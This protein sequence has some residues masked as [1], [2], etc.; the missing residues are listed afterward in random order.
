[1]VL[2]NGSL[3]TAAAPLG[4][5]CSQSVRPLPSGRLYPLAVASAR[6]T[7]SAA[8]ALPCA[9]RAG[10]PCNP[11][12]RVVPVYMVSGVHY[13]CVSLFLFSYSH[14]V[15]AVPRSHGCCWTSDDMLNA[16]SDCLHL[17]MCLLG[18][19]E[20]V[21]LLLLFHLLRGGDWPWLFQSSQAIA[22]T[23]RMQRHDPAGQAG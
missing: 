2:T 3:S 15:Q 13:I 23:E 4:A 22:G 14:A 6:P 16:R 10:R 9:L 18:P 8:S 17:G 21:P 12:C 20:V 7:S 11:A 19:G 1:M 5:H